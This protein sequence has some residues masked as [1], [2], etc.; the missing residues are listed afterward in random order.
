MKRLLTVTTSGNYAS[1]N[2]SFTGT[3]KEV[4]NYL[5]VEAC[6]MRR[7]SRMAK[8]LPDNVH[9]IDIS[10]HP[11]ELVTVASFSLNNMS[12]EHLLRIMNKHGIIRY[13]IA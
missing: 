10:L 5:R 13:A 6:K 11:S 9:A 1:S 8:H 7:E 12:I 4:L 3:K 2:S